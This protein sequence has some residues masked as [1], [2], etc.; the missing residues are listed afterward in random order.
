MNRKK[1][2]VLLIAATTCLV[3]LGC[4]QKKDAEDSVAD[5]MAGIL[6]EYMPDATPEQGDWLMLQLS[7]EMPHLNPIT[8]TDAYATWVQMWVFDT[9][10]D[11]DPI[12]LESLPYA[13]ESW[14]I[15]EDHL[16]YTF[17]LRKDIVFSDGVPA[18][19]NDVKFAF[20]MLMDPKVDAP[21]LR[22][23]FNDITACEVLDDYTVRFTCNKP[24]YRHLV[25]LGDLYVIPRHIYG[26]G[27][28]NN[29]PNNRA[30]VGSGMYMMESWETGQ[31]ITLT[32]N[33]HY[34]RTKETRQPYF[35][36]VVYS[37]ITDDNT[38]FQ[39]L[40]RGDLD[41]LAMPAETFMRR[42]NTKKIK[43]QFNRFA[44]SRPAYSYIG[45]NL[46]KPMFSDK[47]T[48]LA[49]TML[50]DRQTICD[51]IYYGQ[52][53]V[54]P[55]NFMPG[56][57]EYNN[58][59]KP[60]PFDPSQ[61]AELLE[62]AGWKH[63]NDGIL[64][65]DGVRFSFEVGTT[66]QNPIAEKI[67]TIYKEEL[68]RVGIELVIR[69]MEWASLLERVDKREFDA[70]LM[71]WMMPPDPDPYQV[72]HS[73]QA[74][75]GSNY[76]GYVNEESD[77]IIEEARTE[78]DREKRIALYYRFQ[79]ILYDEQPYLFL[80]TPKSLVAADKRIEGMRVYPFGFG[81]PEYQREWFV[82]KSLQ[83]YGK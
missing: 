81:T 51:K 65:R 45:W 63:G 50:M 73:S 47:T 61:A 53:Q 2:A 13:A 19:A 35:D 58:A 80:L 43:A 5:A 39:V 78:F 69:P 55:G 7:A 62:K 8:S 33:P 49:L 29:H 1:C 67:L 14:E 18:T 12:T 15:S 25:M 75:A 21:H 77:R 76:I 4:S 6:T 82:P 34:W 11:R 68:A 46:R 54:I 66:I 36:K 31:K 64:E 17:H 71:S 30:P 57:P 56:T 79:E 24:Y 28:F 3:F 16:Q 20:D 59:I 40:S 48:R 74:D 37:I 22:S 70:I 83:R 26:E 9:L 42:A 52:A 38:A 72:W 41:F 32:R 10:L 44:Y 60:V 23:Y 27:D